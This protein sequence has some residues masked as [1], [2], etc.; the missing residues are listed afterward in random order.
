ME[1][2]EML[3]ESGSIELSDVTKRLVLPSEFVN[4]L[5]QSRLG[6]IIKGVLERDTLYTDAFVARERARLSGTIAAL[7]RPTPMIQFQSHVYE[8][9]FDPLVKDLK[10]K[11]F[12]QVH[13][14]NMLYVP[15][16]FEGAIQ[17][18][19]QQFLS[20]VCYLTMLL[21]VIEW[22]HFA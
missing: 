21:T 10:K 20:Q 7:T 8:S 18:T 13:K 16:V 22:L 9:L 1:I 19:V 15:K 11:I 5:V 6:T 4:K 12:G 14:P 3:H 2:D 17:S